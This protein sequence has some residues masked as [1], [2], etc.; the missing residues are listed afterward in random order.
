[1]YIE[2]ITEPVTLLKRG[3]DDL[4][5]MNRRDWTRSEHRPRDKPIAGAAAHRD[6]ELVGVYEAAG[7][8][9]ASQRL[10]KG[11]TMGLGK[12]DLCCKSCHRVFSVSV[13][14][15][16]EHDGA[17]KCPCCGVTSRYGVAQMLK[18]AA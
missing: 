11:A 5:E 18:P 3:L 15:A 14:E 4:K 7:C 8:V 12:I 9:N 17:I 2:T 6:Q 16:T 1:M 10:A 13:Q